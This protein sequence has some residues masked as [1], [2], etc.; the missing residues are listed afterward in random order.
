MSTEPVLECLA[1]GVG[2][3][4]PLDEDGVVSEDLRFHDGSE[5]WTRA[6]GDSEGRGEFSADVLES[7]CVATKY[8]GIVSLPLKRMSPDRDLARRALEADVSG[9]S[10]SIESF[11]RGEPVGRL[12]RRGTEVVDAAL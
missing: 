8:N 11:R 2:K 10:S 6:A 9:F 7:P 1:L 3:T 5:S 12:K 4:N